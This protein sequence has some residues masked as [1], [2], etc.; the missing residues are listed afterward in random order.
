MKKIY[1][2]PEIEMLKIELTEDVLS[3]SQ[4]GIIYPENPE[5]YKDG[6]S[7]DWENP[8]PFDDGGSFDFDW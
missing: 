4:P 7:G 2:S 6:G 8:D 1:I 5:D 3:K